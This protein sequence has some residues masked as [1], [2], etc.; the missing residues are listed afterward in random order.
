MH[1]AYQIAR[2]RLAGVVDSAIVAVEEAKEM[3][4]DAERAVDDEQREIERDLSAI[5]LP[6]PFKAPTPQ[7]DQP[8]PVP[9]YSSTDDWITAT[10]KLIA[11]C[12][13]D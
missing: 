7:F 5:D 12:K 3:L 13:L 10:K 11:R 8:L 2:V 9:L 1:P 4:R 6:D